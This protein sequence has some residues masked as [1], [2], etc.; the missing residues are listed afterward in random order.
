MNK[1]VVRYQ[2]NSRRTHVFSSSTISPNNHDEDGVVIDKNRSAASLALRGRE[3]VYLLLATA[4]IQISDLP[5]AGDASATCW[6]S[7]TTSISR[8]RRQRERHR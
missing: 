5:S 4:Q 2:H 1:R 8:R 7:C 6:K 3:A